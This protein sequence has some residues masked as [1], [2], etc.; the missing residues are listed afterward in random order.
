MLIYVVYCHYM[1]CWRLY[2]EFHWWVKIPCFF[3]CVL[4]YIYI[5][6]LFFCVVI[7]CEYL[8]GMHTLL[9]F[10]NHFFRNYICFQTFEGT[11]FVSSAAI[12]IA[13]GLCSILTV[14]CLLCVVCRLRR[15]SRHE[16]KWYPQPEKSNTVIPTIQLK[17]HPQLPWER[18]Q[19][20]P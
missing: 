17:Q 12:G 14:I 13:I 7:L 16:E 4:Y 6:F 9:L 20:I 11:I 8:W 19:Y 18:P 10:A 2:E 15:G 5:C 1:F 3:R